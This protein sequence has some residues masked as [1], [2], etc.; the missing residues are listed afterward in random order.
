M[1]RFGPSV[2]VIAVIVSLFLHF[3]LLRYTVFNRTPE[4][5]SESTYEVTLKYYEPPEVKTVEKKKKRTIRKKKKPP[6]PRAEDV[7]LPSPQPQPEPLEVKDE[8]VYLDM[9]VA[10]NG[11]DKI[12]QPELEQQPSRE[13]VSA[14]TDTRYEESI[15]D[16]RSKI[17]KRKIYPQA[18]R[19]RNIEGV[20]LVFLELNKSGELVNLQV[21]ESSGSKILD[22]AALSLIKK[23]LPHEHGLNRNL[24]VEIP[25]RYTL[26]E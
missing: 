1:R 20:V 4:T 18:A 6:E 14:E 10:L 8:D 19:R 26:T 13:Q 11:E 3:L 25:V 9:E 17:L 2:L 22:N 16:L 23:V 5:E 21:V 15:V 24:T 12:V 7:E